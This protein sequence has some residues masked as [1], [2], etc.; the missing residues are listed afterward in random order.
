MMKRERCLWL[1]LFI[2]LAWA[3]RSFSESEVKVSP[4]VIIDEFKGT[5]NVYLEPTKFPGFSKGSCRENQ[6]CSNWVENHLSGMNRAEAVSSGYIVEKEAG[7]GKYMVKDYGISDTRCYGP[8]EFKSGTEEYARADKATGGGWISLGNS[9]YTA[10]EL[11]TENTIKISAGYRTTTKAHFTWIVRVEGLVP[12]SFKCFGGGEVS[13]IQMRPLFCSAQ[14]ACS[15]KQDF[16]GGQV[17]TRLYIKGEDKDG[18][19]VKAKKAVKAEDGTISY[20]D[21]N[22]YTSG[23]YDVDGYDAD[24]Y[25]PLDPI[26]EMTLPARDPITSTTEMTPGDPTVTGSRVVTKDDFGGE[27]LPAKIYFKLM[28]YNDSPVVA[29]SLGNQRKL[30]VMLVPI[31]DIKEK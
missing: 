18:S 28:W 4:K 31:T 3:G 2:S 14:H 25:A 19:T 13:G 17:K 16:S 30:N 15:I 8:G 23:A 5:E 7:S 1:M 10:L 26:T 24:S 29:K 6:V 11:G 9:E 21:Y 12:N 27:K 22:A 20:E